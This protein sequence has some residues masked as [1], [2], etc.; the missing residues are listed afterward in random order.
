MALSAIREFIDIFKGA[1][2]QKEIFIPAVLDEV[3]EANPEEWDLCN[4]ILK[5]NKNNNMQSID[6]ATSKNQ[7]YTIAG[8]LMSII[9]P[10]NFIIKLMDPFIGNAIGLNY[11]LMGLDRDVESIESSDI[12][13]FL[14]RAPLVSNNCHVTFTLCNAASA[15]VDSANVL[16]LF[17]VPPSSGGELNFS[18][19]ADVKLLMR[20]V[21][22]KLK[23]MLT[24]PKLEFY[25][26]LLGE[27][28][29]G[30]NTAGIFNWLNKHPHLARIYHRYIYKRTD[31]VF[32]GHREILLFRVVLKKKCIKEYPLDNI[33]RLDLTDDPPFMVEM[34]HLSNVASFYLAKHL[35]KNL[36]F[37]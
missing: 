30:C 19:Y 35:N 3:E 2:S 20:Y 12:T 4:N 22:K 36:D 33:D 17:D 7:I 24:N 23:I 13:D 1:S 29:A 11:F 25:V 5:D 21:A 37:E 18:N 14:N 8:Y 31:S 16:L 27:I 6:E 9:L 32:K 28:G 26:L 34:G 15:N 10:V